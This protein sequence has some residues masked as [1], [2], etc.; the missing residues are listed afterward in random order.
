MIRNYI[1]TSMRSL[2]KKLSFTVV[3]VLGLALGLA[4]CLLIFLFVSYDTSYDNF[5][6]ENVHR[7][8]L[9]RVYPEREVNYAF[10]PHSIGPQMVMD[11][12]EV[13]NQARLFQVFAPNTLRY[14]DDFFIEEKIIFADSNLFEV[15][16]LPLK[17]GDPQSALN[18]PNAVVLTESSAA[19]IF[20]GE[21][22]MGKQIDFQ[23][24]NRM[25]TGIAYDYPENSHIG[26]E[27][28]L[29]LNSIQFFKQS[30]WLSFSAM[31]YIKLRPNSTTEQVEEKIPSFLK[32]YAD[33]QMRQQNGVSFD[34]YIE[35]GNG[36]NYTLQPIQSIHLHSNLEGE[37]KPN[38]NITYVYIFSIVALF[39]LAIA[40]INFMNLS[41]AR[42]TERGKEVGIRK[43]LGSGKGQLIGQFLTESTLITL[44]AGIVAVLITSLVLP[45]FNEIAGRPLSVS[46]F[47]SPIHITGF[48]TLLVFIGILSGIYPAFFI[49]SFKPVTVLKGKLRHSKSGTGLRNVLVVVQFAISIFLIS[50]TILV[51]SQMNYLMNK[52]LG[53]NKEGVVVIENAFNLDP[54]AT[55]LNWNKYETFRTEI[56]K[57]PGVIG[58]SFTSGMPG[59]LLPGYTIRIPGGSKESYAIRNIVFDEQISSTLE[60]QLNE[61]RFF[62]RSFNDSLSMILN[63]AAVTQ[64]GISNPIGSKLINVID[65]ENQVEYTIVG[66]VE[67]FHFQS[68]HV[69]MEP[70]AI[71][72]MAG[73]GGFVSKAVVRISNDEINATMNDIESV[74][75]SFVTNSPFQSYFLE[76]DLEEFYKSEQATGKIFSIFTFLAILIA[77]IG[78][79]GL[80]AFIINQRVK[81]IGVRKVLGASVPSIILLLSKDFTKL[82]AIA[83]IIS[84]PLAYIWMS[85]W[86]ENFAYATKINLFVFALAAGIALAIGLFTVGMQSIKAAMSN[87]VNSLKDE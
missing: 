1:M 22:P 29:P 13:E 11:F 36:Y 34:E 57:L 85:S 73:Q 50:A 19:K 52:P 41:T 62:E 79:L 9:N 70:I 38:G 25:V 83:A 27:Y 40:C 39:I 80:S 64:L 87:P 53:Y 32:Q 49:S 81:E 45:Y 78:L 75:N 6:D 67:D 84:I 20:K 47:S 30:N 66:V 26:F 33:G 60:M 3:N 74:W 12:P 68:L 23:G 69:S 2:Y 31:T 21:D 37:L 35:A 82:I 76:A 61:G 71:T 63:E 55:Q 8:V 72:N 14:N 59:D 54:N 4:T 46:Q 58:T 56:N 5:Q 48:L 17:E 28:I 16:Y 18:D 24:Q 43:V 44:M 51:Y 86:L 65:E 42:S 10:I 15:F 7:I 77:C